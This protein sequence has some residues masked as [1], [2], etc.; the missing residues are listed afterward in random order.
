MVGYRGPQS[1]R[2][3]GQFNAVQSYV[4]TT[5]V[6]RHCVATATGGGSAYWAGSGESRTYVE[7]IITALWNDMHFRQMQLPGGQIMIGDAVISTQVH[8]GP[9]DEIVWH[10]ATYHVEGDSVPVTLGGQVWYRTILRR[11]DKTG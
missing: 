2:I 1:G 10:G 5:G 11:G 8:L 4:G 7:H 3:N 9:N 6:W